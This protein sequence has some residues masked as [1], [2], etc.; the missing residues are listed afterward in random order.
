MPCGK[1]RQVG[2]KPPAK[3]GGESKV[4]KQVKVKKPKKKTKKR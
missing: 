4:V 2:V 3:F 1:G